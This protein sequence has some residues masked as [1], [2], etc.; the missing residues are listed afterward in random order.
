MNIRTKDVTKL[1]TEYEKLKYLYAC[2]VLDG[3]ELERQ[4]MGLKDWQ[5]T[6]NEQLLLVQ[7]IEDAFTALLEQFDTKDTNDF[8]NN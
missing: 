6:E 3:I 8:E 5:I 7:A 1:E 4:I 2:G